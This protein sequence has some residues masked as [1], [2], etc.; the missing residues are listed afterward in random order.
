MLL[1]CR[2][3]IQLLIIAVIISGTALS[4]SSP[5]NPL[6]QQEVVT[7]LNETV[8]W[9]H[10][11]AVEQE[12]ATNPRDVV[13]VNDDRPLA[14]QIVRLSFEFARASI[15]IVNN[16][17]APGDKSTPSGDTRRQAL[18]QTASKLQDQY[19]KTR[20]ELDALREKMDSAPPRRRKAVESQIA[21]VQSE[22]AALQ[23]RQEA[24]RNIM[25]FIGGA[26]EP[27]GLASE[28]ETFERSVPQFE[29][30]R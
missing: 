2:L 9:Y 23:V 4:E 20:T 16:S 11:R 26:A 1:V 25:Q 29:L 12:I 28:I 27:G 8:N 22:L 18:E 30:G 13:F 10:A 21:E 7:F 6:G 15:P 3:L 14:D 19:N 17:S 5:S 24:L